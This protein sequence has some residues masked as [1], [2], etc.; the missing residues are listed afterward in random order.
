[1]DGLVSHD[2]GH[3]GLG[4][5]SLDLSCEVC[6]L[7]HSESCL[8]NK[9]RMTLSTGLSQPGSWN[10]GHALS[11][12]TP[13][14]FPQTSQLL[15]VW[16]IFESIALSCP[17]NFLCEQ[18]VQSTSCLVPCPLQRAHWIHPRPRVTLR[19]S[20]AET[21]HLFV[22]SDRYSTSRENEWENFSI[23]VQFCCSLVN[24]F[25][26]VYFLLAVVDNLENY[27]RKNTDFKS[28]ISSIQE[29]S[30]SFFKLLF[31]TLWPF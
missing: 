2:R 16:F 28:L 11:Y 27:F 8:Q 12:T 31:R 14:F 15:I 24:E 30:T 18:A 7:L 23:Q 6:P 1:M 26:Y 3:D 22:K 17:L 9:Q 19:W 10:T 25:S 20:T 29:N 4:R 21:Y 5:V 13:L